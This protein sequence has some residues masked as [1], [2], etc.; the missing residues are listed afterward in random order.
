MFLLQT[1]I[2]CQIPKEFWIPEFVRFIPSIGSEAIY[3]ETYSDNPES[4]ERNVIKIDPNGSF[5]IVLRDSAV[6]DIVYID[7]RKSDFRCVYLENRDDYVRN[8]FISEKARVSVQ[9]EHFAVTLGNQRISIPKFGIVESLVFDSAR[10]LFYTF[11]NNESALIAH[12]YALLDD[13]GIMKR[14]SKQIS[15]FRVDELRPDA[16]VD[17]S[18]FLYAYLRK[19]LPGTTP[20]SYTLGGGGFYRIDISTGSTKELLHISDH[21][22]PH[23]ENVQRSTTFYWRSRDLVLVALNDRIVSVKL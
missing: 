15:G 4:N 1:I 5:S 17:R 9:P 11:E 16:F 21:F 13:G 18:G 6:R 12:T 23:A 20:A 8:T 14:S 7:E 2:L 19:L 3:G 22:D 10:T